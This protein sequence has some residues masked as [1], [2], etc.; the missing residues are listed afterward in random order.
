MTHSQLAL[1][2]LALVVTLWVAYKIGKVVL[3]IAAGLAFLA[4]VAAAIWYLNRPKPSITKPTRS[5]HGSHLLPPLR[6]EA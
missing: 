5:Q 6:R 3:R 1:S 4:L 2:A